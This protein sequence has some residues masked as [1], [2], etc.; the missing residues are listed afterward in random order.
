MERANDI[1]KKG[2]AKKSNEE[3]HSHLFFKIMLLK[4][5]NITKVDLLDEE[6]A[7]FSF[8]DLGGK[9]SQKSIDFK[10]ANKSLNNFEKY[11]QGK[12]AY[13]F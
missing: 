8:L 12:K 11:C 1:I 9:E 10:K 4:N 3:N 7:S 13:S 6:L 5:E 2:I